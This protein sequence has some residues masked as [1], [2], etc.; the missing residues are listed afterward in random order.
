MRSDDP[1][2]AIGWPDRPARSGREATRG[3]IVRDQLS[4]D[5]SNRNLRNGRLITDC[6]GMAWLLVA[7]R[8]ARC[9]RTRTGHPG[10]PPTQINGCTPWRPRDDDRVAPFWVAGY[11]R[12]SAEF[13]F[14]ADSESRAPGHGLQVR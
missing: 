5:R 2:T 1:I 13:S 4:Q 7:A 12:I 10:L 6:T 8:P 9:L 14:E 11:T 3:L